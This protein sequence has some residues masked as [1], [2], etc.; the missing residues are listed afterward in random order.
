MA[1]TFKMN[2]LRVQI[3]KSKELTNGDFVSLYTIKLSWKGLHIIEA[4]FFFGYLQII[5]H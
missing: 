4:V 5:F 2:F 1:S 3:V